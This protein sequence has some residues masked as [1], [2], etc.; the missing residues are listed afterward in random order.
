MQFLYIEK[1]KP[2]TKEIK[3]TWIKSLYHVHCWKK[4]EINFSNI[5][6][7]IQYIKILL[8]QYV[9]NKIIIMRYFTFFIFN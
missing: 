3:K 8:S 1:H 9:T 7:L 5:F 6:Y 4:D 2:L